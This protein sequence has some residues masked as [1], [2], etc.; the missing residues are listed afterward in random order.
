MT[1]RPLPKVPQQHQAAVGRAYDSLQQK[2]DER[3]HGKRT[4]GAGVGGL[5]GAMAGSFRGSLGAAL[6]AGLGALV[7]AVVG[8]VLERGD[9]TRRSDPTRPDELPAT[10]SAGAPLSRAGGRSAEVVPF[11]PA[12][13]VAAARRR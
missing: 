8:E 11:A 6:G 1:Q 5:L 4:V 7:G 13:P 9:Q 12:P 3:G 10:S 2:A